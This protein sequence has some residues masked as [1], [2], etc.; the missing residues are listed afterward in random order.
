[1]QDLT[2][3]DNFFCQE[4]ATALAKKSPTSL[5]VS[6]RA[7]QLG[8]NL[9]FDQCM[10]QEFRLVSHFLQEHD[11]KCWIL[12]LLNCSILLAG[13]QE[14]KLEESRVPQAES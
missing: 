11:L 3:S 7:L 8:A 9:N 12:L 4:A 13:L 2:T 6:L 1:M 14:I 5:K 10:Q